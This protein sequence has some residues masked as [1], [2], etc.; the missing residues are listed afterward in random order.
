VFVRL[1]LRF[2][3]VL[4]ISLLASRPALASSIVLNGG[5]ETGN[6]TSWTVSHASMN[7]AV[8]VSGTNPHSG[9]FAL[10]FAGQNQGG[11]DEDGVA[12]LLPTVSGQTYILDFWLKQ[13]IVPG[14][15]P[16][17]SCLY[18]DFAAFWN[19]VPVMQ[20]VSAPAF[21][22]TEFMVSV[23][24]TGPFS[25]LSF[26]AASE[27]GFFRLDDVSVTAVPEPISLALVFGGLA[28]WGVSRRRMR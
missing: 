2:M 14:C 5:F 21:G 16:A 1:T 12:E 23:I 26:K 8:A 17:G 4:G 3:F 15:Q 11:G 9:S 10:A 25:T 24:A 27:P 13:E 28:A 18:N 19:G 20:M 7:S 6:L 22:Y